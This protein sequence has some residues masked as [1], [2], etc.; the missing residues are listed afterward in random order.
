MPKRWWLALAG[1]PL[2]VGLWAAG[3]AE[4]VPVTIRLFGYDRQAGTVVVYADGPIESKGFKLEGPDRWVV[5]IPNTLYRGSLSSLNAV[6]GSGIKQI[7]IGQF[8]RSSVR[9]VFDLENPVQIP[10]HVERKML[11]DGA[12]YR[13]VFDIPGHCVA[14]IDATR[15]RRLIKPAV[16]PPPQ[17]IAKTALDGTSQASRDLEMPTRVKT[18]AVPQPS[19]E[20]N[21]PLDWFGMLLGHKEAIGLET[22]AGLGLPT[23]PLRDPHADE[24]GEEPV[25]VP[26]SGLT[27]R[28]AGK[29]WIMRI[30][31]DK[32]IGY[33]LTRL[34]R[35]DRLYLDV[36][37]GSVEIPKDSLYVDNGLVARVRKGPPTDGNTRMVVELD[38]ALRYEAHLSEDKRSVVLGLSRSEPRTLPGNYED[39]VTIDA[40]H[41]GVD[42]GTIGPAGTFEKDVN[43]AMA[44]R[45]QGLLQK[46]GVDVQ[47]TRSKDTELLL[48]PR[49]EMGD[50]FSSDA[51]VSIHMN[52]APNTGTQGI[53]TYYFTPQSQALA[54]NVH[55]RMIKSLGRPDRGV[56]R[57]QFV[58]VKYSKMPAVLVEVGYLSNRHEE[59]LLTTH[60]YQQKAAEAITAGVQDFL[61]QQ[62]EQA[63]KHDISHDAANRWGPGPAHLEANAPGLVSKR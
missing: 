49:V 57:A 58:V 26:V 47:L 7:R 51:F 30:T 12:Q 59:G 44:A 31:A 32:P 43:L 22:T 56:R 60:E 42:P 19:S 34:G 10:A 16:V 24:M 25:P 41:G 9:V 18:T 61:R 36:L 48:H 45:L 6:P 40:G 55:K 20:P 27:L 28:R 62:H 3:A 35:R 17:P 52:S 53:E 15:P 4:S 14:P 29:S 46:A 50:E 38:Q 23:S 33:R 5:D 63:R 8:T 2:V 37:G 11:G 21:S 1:I 54:R 39:R 13:L